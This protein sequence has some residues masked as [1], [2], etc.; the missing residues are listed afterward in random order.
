MTAWTNKNPD[1]PERKKMFEELQ[2]F[3]VEKKLQTPPYELV[4]FCDYQTA[5]TN[6]LK[7]DGQKNVKYI[8]DL[9]K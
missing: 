7:P 1:S 4:P 3:F 2:Q 8:L 6:T 5:V 9:T